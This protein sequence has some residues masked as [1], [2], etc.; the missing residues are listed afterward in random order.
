MSI[1]SLSTIFVFLILLFVKFSA[2]SE[3]IA[4][5]TPNQLSQ[6]AEKANACAQ[7]F[8]EHQ[9][10]YG[11]NRLYVREYTGTEPTVVLMHGFPD[12]LH[13]Y[14][15]VVPYLC[16]RHVVLFDFLGWGQSDK[17]ENYSYTFDDQKAQLDAIIQQLDLQN[18]LL[19][20]HDASGPAAINWALDHSQET[21]GLVLLNTFY[22]LTPS[23]SAPE[24]IAIFA[25]LLEFRTARQVEPTHPWTFSRLSQ[26]IAN[27]KNMFRWLYFWQVGSFFRDEAVR[28]K[29]LPRLYE[30]FKEAP[31]TIPAFV[32]LNQDLGHS[33]G[34]NSQRVAEL[35]AFDG[36]VRI[37]FGASDPYLNADLA[38]D[39]HQVFPTSELFLLPTARHY[40][41]MD[42]PAQVAHLI[43]TAKTR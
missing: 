30:Q 33:I 18:P 42:E 39:F 2:H 21:G 34:A 19:V 8:T 4:D 16:G 9:V 15:R 7:D 13:L 10:Q 36:P 22:H 5:K 11:E 24:A 23:L 37:I 40:V 12:N 3:T 6:P 32:K 20:S 41:Q 29:F 1:R 14:D 31:S 43:L 38:K 26:A 28:E 17:P 35:I 27:D 25:D